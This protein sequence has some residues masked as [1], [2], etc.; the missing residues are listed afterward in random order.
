M[1]I[2][3]FLPDLRFLYNNPVLYYYW[4]VQLTSLSRFILLVSFCEEDLCIICA[5]ILLLYSTGTIFTILF[6]SASSGNLW[7]NL[8]KMF[9]G[10]HHVLLQDCMHVLFKHT[11][12]PIAVP[13]FVWRDIF[14]AILFDLW[15]KVIKLFVFGLWIQ[16]HPF[17]EDLYIT[18]ANHF[19]QKC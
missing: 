6:T 3:L 17:W 9:E 11:L 1:Q 4:K 2:R 8:H 15:W 10:L 18:K 14:I 5:V 12:H 13:N 7:Y 19:W 16:E